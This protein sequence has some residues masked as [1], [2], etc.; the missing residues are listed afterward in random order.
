[1]AEIERKQGDTITVSETFE[2]PGSRSSQALDLSD[3]QSVKIYVDHP[4]SGDL[5]VK[6]TAE[7]TD[8]ANGM[9]EYTLGGTQTARQGPH[10]LEFVAE[11]AGGETFSYPQT[12][13]V[14]LKVTDPAARELPVEELA[15]GDASVTELAADAI[16]ANTA[17]AVDVMD[18]LDLN[19]NPITSLPVP[20]NP[21][22]AARKD[23]LDTVASDLSSVESDLT[24]QVTRFDALNDTVEALDELAID[25]GPI[26]SR[27]T[28]GDY[29]DQMYYAVDQRIL[30]RWDAGSSDWTAAGGLGVSSQRLPV[31]S[32]LDAV[33]VSTLAAGDVNLSGTLTGPKLS[34]EE[35][36]SA[37][38]VTISDDETVTYGRDHVHPDRGIEP[39]SVAIGVGARAP[40]STGDPGWF[41]DTANSVAIGYQ[42]L[43]DNTGANSNGVG[44]RA[45]ANN[46]GFASNGVG[47]RALASNTGD[48]SNGVGYQALRDN[49]GFASNAVGYRALANNTGDN[50][51]GVGHQALQDN[52]GGDSNGVG[53]EALRNN[54][55]FGSNAVG[56]QALRDNTGFASNAVGY[57]ALANNTGTNSNGVGYRALRDNTGFASNG[58]GHQALRDNTGDNSNGVGHRA[59][60]NNTGFASNGVG[61]RALEGDGLSNPSDM[62]SNVNAFGSEAGRNNTGEG[63]IL[64]GQQAGINNSEDDVLLITD[65]NGETRLKMD[66]TNGNMKIGGSLSENATLN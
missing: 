36:D 40:D 58:V 23:G 29:D 24:S 62:G 61:Y 34:A 33:D 64:I 45:L 20:S 25:R 11:F 37:Q 27:P 7:I 26:S 4:S 38:S 54:T 15:D 28:S 51:N 46:T 12:G 43:R 55:G 1:M 65:R 42:A 9:V 32:Y 41:N 63:A 14:S 48:N 16:R 17:S 22:D 60:A 47:H 6:D 8:A 3:A 31:T 52:T 18:A 19:N 10:R 2:R 56:Y 13:F 66:L 50:S 21:A 39:N 59:L 5:V 57:R 30:W 49:T 53:Y 35:I 44:Y